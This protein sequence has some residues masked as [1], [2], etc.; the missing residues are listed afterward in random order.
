MSM[1]QYVF[2]CFFFA[3]LSEKKQTVIFITSFYSF[4]DWPISSSVV[5]YLE[6]RRIAL[7]LYTM[8]ADKGRLICAVETAL[9]AR[10]K[11]E[12]FV[13]TSQA[14]LRSHAISMASDRIPL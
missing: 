8:V 12:P 2:L 3:S 7:I 6:S 5:H 11:V 1:L 13:V 14:T 4:E 10:K 9:A